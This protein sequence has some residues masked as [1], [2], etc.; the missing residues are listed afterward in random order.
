MK[1]SNHC[2]DFV[3][4]LF[5]FDFLLL[6]DGNTKNFIL[7]RPLIP[8]ITFIYCHYQLI[9]SFLVRTKETRR[10]QF[11]SKLDF[12]TVRF[13]AVNQWFLDQEDLLPI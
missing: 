4:S 12:S 3:F 6:T 7:F 9:I 5:C 2:L 11:R 10:R 13:P 8:Q 1:A